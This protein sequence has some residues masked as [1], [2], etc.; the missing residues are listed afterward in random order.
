MRTAIEPG[1]HAFADGPVFAAPSSLEAA[2][3]TL[4]PYADRLDPAEPA[5]LLEMWTRFSAGAQIGSGVLLGLGARLVNLGEPDQV[6][7]TGPSALRGVLR[8]EPAGRIEIAPFVYAGDNTLISAQTLVRIGRATLLAHN[9]QI[10]DNNSHPTNA[11]QREVQFRRML[12]DKSVVAPMEIDTA[13]VIIGER[14]W[15][16]MNSL[17]MRG[18]TIGDD[19]IVA[20]GSVVTRSLPSGVIAAGNPAAIVRE[21]TPAERAGQPEHT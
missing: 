21:L 15:I 1:D 10:F 7:I 2:R 17:V 13:P 4:A 5:R 16:G 6:V 18:V 19:T 14:C 3:E 9:V 12:G 8:A 11:Y 20:A